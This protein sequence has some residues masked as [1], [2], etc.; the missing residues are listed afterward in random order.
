MKTIPLDEGFLL[1]QL[2]PSDGGF[3]GLN[4]L[5]LIEEGKALFLDCGYE[6]NMREALADLERRGVVPSGAIVSH[7]H[8]DHDGGLRL[9]GDIETWG[10][11]S[12]LQSAEKWLEPGQS[13]APGPKHIVISRTEL[14]FGKRRLV[15]FPLPGHSDDSLAVLVDDLWLYVADAILLA[16]D[17]RPLLPSVHSRPVSRH[18]EAIDALDRLTRYI[19]IPGHGSV[20]SD[21]KERERDLRNR[22]LYLT[23]IASAAPASAASGAVASGPAAG[24]TFDEATAGCDP[25]FLGREWHEHNY[26]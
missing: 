22:R 6:P 17:G 3:E 9:L 26:R 8:P 15:L 18:L 20:M 25:P 12:W 14:G 13:P 4:F 16:N 7:Y 21:R 23:A 2:D 1:Y 24:I 19:F 5:V 10:G 11:E